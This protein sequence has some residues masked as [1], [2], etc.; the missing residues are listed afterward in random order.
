MKI[1]MLSWE[2]PPVFTGGLGVA[3]EGIANALSQEVDLKVLVP[4]YS[5]C[6]EKNYEVIGL[7]KELIQTQYDNQDELPYS[8]QISEE[9]L[10]FRQ[11]T[12]ED[13]ASLAKGGLYEDVADKV[14]EYTNKAV[15]EGKAYPCDIIYAHDWLTALAGI[16]LKK[17]LKKPLVFHVHSLE[18]D[19]SGADVTSKGSTYE[20]ERYAMTEA[21]K[22][23]VVSEY[24]ARVCQFYYGID[25]SK[26]TVV[27]NGLEECEMRRK[28][29]NK[30]RKEV[31]FLGRLTEQKGPYNF[32][33]IAKKV[34][35]K[36]KEVRFAM[37]G[38]GEE[39]GGLMEEQIKSELEGNVRFTGYLD[40][41]EVQKLFAVADVY[42]MPSVSEPFG[43]SALEA[44]QNGVPVVISNQSG[45]S[46]VLSGAISLD[47]WEIQKMAD[48]IN[49]LL[50]DDDVYESKLDMLSEDI[51][52]VS[53]S[54]TATKLKSI[55]DEL[56]EDK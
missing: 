44:V 39:L 50:L 28:P 45:V 2:F 29:M 21:D 46:E 3:C 43:L 55:F 8:Y 10:S 56:V 37:A 17:Q 12:K 52:K 49:K 32:L 27:H 11:E 24:T 7:S 36:N 51:K 42:C 34:L 54:R 19:R 1:L 16:E 33:K 4:R 6:S 53:W 31:V 23:V 26:I 20:I 22:V 35:E 30:T 15:K 41:E 9:F 48:G 18:Y 13:S 40:K 25:A 47:Y 5:E 38:S 14:R